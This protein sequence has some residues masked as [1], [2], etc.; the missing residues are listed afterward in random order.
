MLF[1]YIFS[2]AF[3]QVD[4]GSMG[5]AVSLPDY[6]TPHNLPFMSL[7]P[8]KAQGYKVKVQSE[9][10]SASHFPYQLVMMT[11]LWWWGVLGAITV[12]GHS[13]GD[14]SGGAS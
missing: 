2:I 9:N 1:N 6:C 10:I 12:L 5:S 13:R 14:Y 4:R 3:V 7:R 11:G 8:D